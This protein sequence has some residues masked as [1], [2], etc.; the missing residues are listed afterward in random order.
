MHKEV[1]TLNSAELKSGGGCPVTC[2]ETEARG[3][4]MTHPGSRYQLS[5]PLVEAPLILVPKT[6]AWP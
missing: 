1:E 4:V 3:G 6:H 5:P 2:A